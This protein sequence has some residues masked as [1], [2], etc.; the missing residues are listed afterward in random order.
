MTRKEKRDKDERFSTI[1]FIAGIIGIILL[2]TVIGISHHSK[3][4]MP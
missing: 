3:D 1:M 4:F 2:L